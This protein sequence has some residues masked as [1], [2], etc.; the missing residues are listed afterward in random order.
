MHTSGTQRPLE[1][2]FVYFSKALLLLLREENNR[3]FN[4]LFVY[5]VVCSV[6]EIGVQNQ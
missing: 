6:K 2:Q 1:T 4:S 5:N 3:N